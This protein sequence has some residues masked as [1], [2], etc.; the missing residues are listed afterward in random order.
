V[1]TDFENSFAVGNS[2]ESS[3]IMLL[4]CHIFQGQAVSVG[5]SMKKSVVGSGFGVYTCS[6][7]AAVRFLWCTVWCCGPSWRASGV[8]AW[9]ILPSRQGG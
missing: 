9:C 3:A 4:R 2:N 6:P 5:V 7:S 8:R 1:L